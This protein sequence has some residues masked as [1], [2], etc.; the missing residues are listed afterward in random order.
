M[1][2]RYWCPFCSAWNP[3]DECR[4]LECRQRIA[5]QRN[6]PNEPPSPDMEPVGTLNYGTGGGVR[7]I[8]TTRGLS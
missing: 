7:I 4:L 3:G 6:E 5:K 2:K 8:R 1:G